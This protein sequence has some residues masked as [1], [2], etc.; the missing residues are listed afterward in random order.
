[1]K[2][3][4]FCLMAIINYQLLVAQ[5]VGIGTTTPTA[6]LQI[7]GQG[8]SSSTN[9]LMLKNSSGDTLLRVLD[10]GIVTMGYNAPS[11]TR[12]FSLGGNGMNFYYPGNGAYTGAIY[13]SSS[14]SSLVIT[15]GKHL[16]LQSNSGNIGVGNISPAYRLDV[17]GIVH[18]SDNIYVDGRVGIGTTLPNLSAQL[19]V[20]STSKGLLIPRMTAIQRVAIVAPAAGLMVYETT[21][22]SFWF[23]NGTVWSPVNTTGD[24]SKWTLNGSDIF[25]NNAGNVGIGIGTPT[26][27]FHLVGNLLQESG[28]MTI[29]NPNAILQMQ[30]A[31]VN[32]ASMR[33]IAGSEFDIGT[34]TGNPG[35]HF[36]IKTN[37]LPR[38]MINGGDGNVGIGGSF[39]SE[40][41][42]VFGNILANGRVDADGVIEGGSLSSL[43]VLYVNET[44]LLQGAVTG[45]STASFTGN[46][47]SNTSISINHPS[48]ILQLKNANIDKGFVQLSGDNLRIGTNSG[49]TLGNVVFRNDGDD[50]IE[51]KKTGTGGAWLQ[52]NKNGV[53]NG[54][55]QATSTG[56]L[57]LSNPIA[58]EQLQL[59]GEIFID[60]TANR[61]GIGTS[62]PTE[63]LHVN[64][65]L[66]VSGTDMTIDD[67]RITGTSTG[68]AYNLLP[69]AYGR[70]TEAGNKAGGT[71]NFTSVNKFNIGFYDVFVTGLTASSI[72]IVTTTYGILVAGGEYQAPGVFRVTTRN[73]NVNEWRDSG[74]QFIIYNP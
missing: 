1:M 9:N 2:K 18:S 59:G 45:N 14:D 63:R 73:T 37:G 12:T 54:V 38:I 25:N 32:K 27:K 69:L 3:I 26:S 43:G 6:K 48:A 20:T 57:S 52:L 68:S 58:N 71:L 41:L 28:T 5:S 22:N 46:I 4:I 11:Y 23:Y 42:Q 40:K 60:N 49:N 65:K 21:S 29:N 30:N 19:D 53:S 36:Y 17:A 55:L 47:N 66:K 39:P 62:S 56:A 74:F 44:S 7:V 24:N 72:I 31:G 33:L 15:G 10:N 35:G 16:I 67:G 64:G 8:S 51:I 61:T 13:P 50:I 70:V 34:N